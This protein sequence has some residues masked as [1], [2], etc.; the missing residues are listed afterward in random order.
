MTPVLKIAEIYKVIVKRDEKK[1]NL[2]VYVS[3][4][5]QVSFPIEDTL[6]LFPIIL[7]LFKRLSMASIDGVSVLY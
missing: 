6:C 7:G 3:E 4:F 5:E 2:G 1:K